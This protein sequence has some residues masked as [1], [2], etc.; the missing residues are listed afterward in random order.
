MALARW[1]KLCGDRKAAVASLKAILCQVLLRKLC[2]QCREAY[3]PPQ[4][5][6]AKLNLPADRIE[7]FYRP[8]TKPLTDEKGKPIVCSNCRGTGYQGRTASFELMEL[9]DDLRELIVG[10]A[11]LGQIKAGC[12]KNKMLYLQE[13]SIRKVI[14]GIT[15]IEEVVRVSKSK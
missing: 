4:N 15:S 9:T 10:D 8:P 5:V 14:A 1:I 6:L 3:R 12:R 13:Q 7:R 2:P 11:S